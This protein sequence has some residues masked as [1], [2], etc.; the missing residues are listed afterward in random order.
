MLRDLSL[1]FGVCMVLANLAGG[2]IVFLFLGLVLPRA[3]RMFLPNIVALAA[4]MVLSVVVGCLWSAHA[5]KPIRDWLRSDRPITTA[6][7]TYV[8]RHPMRQA[9]I[10]FAIWMGSEVVFIPINMRFGF[11]N[12]LDVAHTILMGAI[13]TCGLT[14]LFAERMLRPINELAFEEELP[15][16]KYVPGVKSR[17][18]LAWATGSGVPLLGIVMLTT[19]DQARP[20]S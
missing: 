6:E 13:T 9:L 20:V 18:M 19:D 5:F 17:M 8:V 11:V 7:R 16:D 14:Y 2:A 10:N 15:T 1:H 12:D 3:E 4:Y